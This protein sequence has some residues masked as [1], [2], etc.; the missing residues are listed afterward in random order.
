[1]HLFPWCTRTQNILGQLILTFQIH[2]I[3]MLR[4]AIHGGAAIHGSKEQFLA[5]VWTHFGSFVQGAIVTN[6][7]KCST[8]MFVHV[9]S[10]RMC[11]M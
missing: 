3:S 7:T 11:L 4:Q 1:M 6:S 2:F 8:C 5:L 10:E 9:W